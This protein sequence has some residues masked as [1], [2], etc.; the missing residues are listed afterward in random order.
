M[1]GGEKAAAPPQR[2]SG[3]GSEFFLCFTS[4]PSSSLRALQSPG[5]KDRYREHGAA[6]PP[7]LSR[8]L[9]N[10]GS[11]KGGQS[12]ATIP[13]GNRRKS[14]PVEVAE[15]SSPKVTC[16]GQ[17]K[18][19][20]ARMKQKTK[21]KK[22]KKTSK[23]SCS[24]INGFCEAVRSFGS[25]LNCFS[26][27]SAG[28]K[29][30]VV[31]EPPRKEPEKVLAA[32]EE[33]GEMIE[34]KRESFC[35]VPPRNALLLMRCRSDPVKMAA[36]TT[37][38]CG[39]PTKVGVEDIERE[40]A[41][42]DGATGE[43][44][45]GE[46]QPLSRKDREEEE[47]DSNRRQ[48]DSARRP[49]ERESCREK[50][51]EEPA[52]SSLGRESCR[53]KVSVEEPAERCLERETSVEKVS[54][55]RAQRCSER[56][57]RGEKVSEDRARRCLERESARGKVVGRRHSFST[58][59]D[60]RRKSSA[61][62]K[63]GRRRWSFSVES[64]RRQPAQTQ[65]EPDILAKK[66]KNLKS[67]KKTKSREDP[68]AENEI[69]SQRTAPPPEDS[70]VEELPDC[71]LLMMYEPK[72]SME[73]SKETWVCS[74]DFLAHH[75]HRQRQK[76][77]KAEEQP[78]PVPLPEEPVAAERKPAVPPFGLTRCKSEPMRSSAKM[79]PDTCFWKNRHRPIGEAGVGF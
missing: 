79:D 20:T 63:E 77:T 34:E 14:F 31:A 56:E 73:V 49:L 22:K 41:G 8:R 5:R 50:V 11:L 18:V 4:R 69:F 52:R 74:S 3:A 29:D 24:P 71:L 66:T 6:A 45:V 61:G 28:R 68:E 47:R 70:K 53:E 78:P 38:L 37:R 15:P 36:L 39:S 76:Q 43:S 64:S 58:E 26:P 27:C 13:A 23:R 57:T 51:G 46:E 65:L 32:A 30:T 17:V 48:G 54:E 62:E 33:E 10:S 42:D 9:K 44:T 60:A 1:E 12:P 21:R 67:K 2:P 75:R 7:S 55:D 19:K 16:I 72:L 25:E 59:K 40:N 35:V